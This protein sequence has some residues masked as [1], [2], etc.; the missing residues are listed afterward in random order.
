[1]GPTWTMPT[2]RMKANGEHRV[3]L[4]KRA[5]G[6]AVVERAQEP[7]LLALNEEPDDDFPAAPGAA[8]CA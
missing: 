4:P 2:E 3:P 8:N 5:L 6:A 1:M 7:A